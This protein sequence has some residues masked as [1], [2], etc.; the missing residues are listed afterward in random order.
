MTVISDTHKQKEQRN[1]KEKTRRH[2]V[3]AQA[4]TQNRE[5]VLRHGARRRSRPNPTLEKTKTARASSREFSFLCKQ[6]R[7]RREGSGSALFPDKR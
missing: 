5:T 1:R 2:L 3:R 4:K 6:R 7:W